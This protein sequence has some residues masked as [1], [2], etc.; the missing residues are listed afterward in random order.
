V[1]PATGS[2][3]GTPRPPRRR[4]TGTRRGPR[5]AAGPGTGGRG[6]AG[7]SRMRRASPAPVG[8]LP[9][10]GGPRRGE[11]SRVP[12]GPWSGEGGQGGRTARRP[13]R[14]H[15]RR[16]PWDRRISGTSPPRGPGWGGSGRRA[17]RSKARAPVKAGSLPG[18]ERDRGGSGPRGPGVRC[19]PRGAPGS[20]RPPLPT[21]GQGSPP[22]VRSSG[23]SRRGPRPGPPPTWVRGREGCVRPAIAP[24]A[25][26]QRGTTSL[27]SGRESDLK[28]VGRTEGEGTG[29]SCRVPG[30]CHPSDSDRCPRPK[31]GNPHRPI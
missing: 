22:G 21:G 16:A 19:G 4:R 14:R 11:G 20:T 18:A 13:W 2:S 30:L 25:R 5:D 1:R 12:R 8:P 15:P 24:R 23:G 29:R 17:T 31:T 3:A 7:R 27:E 28:S 9:T 10:R 26:D 6:S